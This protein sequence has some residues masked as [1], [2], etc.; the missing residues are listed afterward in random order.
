MP[1]T[2]ARRI[3]VL[4]DVAGQVLELGDPRRIASGRSSQ[5][6]QAATSGG[7]PT[8]PTGSRPSPTAGRRPGPPSTPQP[9]WTRRARSVMPGRA[10]RAGLD[11]RDQLVE[12]LREAATPSSISSSV[13]RSMLIPRLDLADRLDARRL[14]VAVERALQL[15]VVEE[16]VDRLERHR[17]D[18]LRTDELLDVQHVA[19]VGVLGGGARPQAA[20]HPRAGGAQV[21]E[22]VAAEDL[23]EGLVGELGV[24]DGGLPAQGQGRIGPD[25]VER[26]CRPW[27]R[28]G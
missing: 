7:F 4:A 27:C 18:G 13:T 14:E 6:S 26:A 21:G 23:A 9:R 3:A 16:G 20:L 1:S 10:P 15:A 12:A 19:V 11:R 24:G 17:V 28:P 5:P 2:A 8:R 25:R 22:L